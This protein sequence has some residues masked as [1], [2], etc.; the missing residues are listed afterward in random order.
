MTAPT[1]LFATALAAVLLLGVT[2]C[3][4]D[5]SYTSIGYGYGYD[6]GYSYD[7]SPTYHTRWGYSYG[8]GPRYHAPCDGIRYRTDYV[9]GHH[10][11]G[12]SRGQHIRYGR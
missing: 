12:H 4:Y 8:H 6:Y 5:Y 3:H 1:R 11:H 10:H 9:I 7:C 2:G